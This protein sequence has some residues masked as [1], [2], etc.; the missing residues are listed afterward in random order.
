LIKEIEI[1]GNKNISSG[2]VI[3]IINNKISKPILWFIPGNSFM[4]FKNEEIEV[5][6]INEFSEIKSIEIKKKF[7]NSLE[8]KIDEKNPLIIWCRLDDCYYVDNNGVAFLSAD[9]NLSTGENKKFIKIIEQLEIEEEI[10]KTESNNIENKKKNNVTYKLND[11][12]FEKVRLFFTREKQNDWVATYPDLFAIAGED[13]GLPVLSEIPARST[14]YSL[15]F[16]KKKIDNLKRIEVRDGERIF[17]IRINFN[18]ENK[19]IFVNVIEEKEEGE[20]II[21][22]PIKINDEVSDSDFINFAIEIDK[23]IKDN[24]FLNIKYYKTKGTRSR[25]LIA[26]TDKNTRIYFNATN[27][28]SLQVGYLK[29]FLLKGMDEKKIDI[30][31]YIYLESGNKIF[32]K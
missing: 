15:N 24:T 27:D 2:D 23:G 25:E 6:L 19:S 4:F 16:A 22:N 31:K 20:V 14:L 9:R 21:L 7:P 3:N 28:A 5:V 13:F 26:Y 1:E 11:E 12:Q 18:Y 17:Y 30:L 10:N 32:Y 8:I 29:D